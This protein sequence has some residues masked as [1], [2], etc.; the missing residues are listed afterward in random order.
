MAPQVQVP[1]SH[2]RTGTAE[3]VSRAHDRQVIGNT[4]HKKTRSSGSRASG[5]LGIH[6]T[7]PLSAPSLAE[8]DALVALFNAGRLSEGETM[9]RDVIRRYPKAVFGWKAL[10]TVLLAGDRQREALPA[11]QQALELNPRDSE[12]LNSLGKT[13]QDLG[14]LDAALD[15]I[16]HAL[17]L[18]PDY[19]SA[20]INRGNVL[21]QLGR[22]DE[23][24]VCLDRAL[25]LQPDSASAHNDRGHVLKALGRLD[26]ALAA[27]TRAIALKPGF[28]E[29]HHNLGSVLRDL[30]RFEESLSQYGRA[31][32]LKP[33]WPLAKSQ[34]AHCLK[35]LSFTQDRPEMRA[36]LVQALRESWCRPH[37][38]MVTCVSCIG[39]NPRIESALARLG[40]GETLAAADLFG[41]AGLVRL[42]DEP[43][44]M[45]LL[46][47]CPIA[48]A[49][50]ERLLTQIR[51]ALLEAVTLSA[52]AHRFDAAAQRLLAALARQC[53][54][55]DYA[56]AETA[57]ET[58]R[59]EALHGALSLAQRQRA[60]IAEP[61]LLALAAYRSLLTLPQP[62]ALLDRDWSEPVRAVLIEQVREPLQ[63][64]ED[65]RTMPC[66]TTMADPVSTQ[67]RAQYEEHP[68]PRWTRAGIVT[69]APTIAAYIRQQFPKTRLPAPVRQDGNVSILVAGCGTGL[70]ALEVAQ[71][72]PEARILAIDLSLTSLAYAQRKT[73]ELGVTNVRYAQADILNLGELDES[74]DLI[75]SVG[76]LHHLR[77]PIAGWKALLAHLHPGGFMSIGLYSELARRAVVRVREQIAR[78]GCPPTSSAMR[79]FRQQ[80]LARRETSDDG[81][82]TQ[83][84][85]FYSL[86]GCR[87]L[88][89]HVSEQRFTLPQL[90]DALRELELNLV[91]FILD[92]RV[93]ARYAERFPDDPSATNLESW[94]R[95]EQEHPQAFAGMYQFWVQKTVTP[96][97]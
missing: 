79:A 92:Q 54:L 51:R 96:C 3:P 33:D 42:A 13:L 37:E 67:V 52:A 47:A 62:A 8:Q 57:A 64:A 2:A 97:S 24:L 95:F 5:G 48:D 49:D 46:E 26:E 58:A 73:R 60:P 93:T 87:D 69:P 10:G 21:V 9:A 14:Q 25:A 6:R 11:L 59:I 40:R 88:L 18:R 74:F 77:D 7:A 61:Y 20:L 17:R 80:L 72:Y 78:D 35:R 71:R 63:E 29:A 66:L 43:L 22:S 85:D 45:S 56:W 68:Y 76:V 89:F 19:G 55:N 94:H 23:A 81:H 12:C 44:L 15:A 34:Y 90:A 38:L 84:A 1:G 4:M 86:S 27:Y 65:R 41:A 16:E 28:A 83:S 39:L 32:D 53:H 75:E 91:G 70:H 82:L 31:L 50:L 30:A 36:R